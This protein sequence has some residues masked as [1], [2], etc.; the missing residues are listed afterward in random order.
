MPERPTPMPG[1]GAGIYVHVPFCLRKCCYCDF[2]S[3]P[4]CTEEMQ[5]YFEALA[6]EIETVA[7]E[8]L[9]VPVTSIFVGG[10][11]PS[12][13]PCA[14]LCSILRQILSMFKHSPDVEVSVEVNPGTVNA[15]SLAA[16]RAAGANRLSIGVQ[17]LDS[18]LLELLGRLHTAQDAVTS[19]LAARSAGFTNISIDLMFGLPEQ[20]MPHFRQTLEQVLELTPDHVSCYS[21]I[22]EPSTPLATLLREN[23]L[24]LPDEETELA[25]YEWAIERLRSA[26]YEQYEISNW[27]RPGHRCQHNEIYWRNEWYRGLGP[28]AHSHWGGQRWANTSDVEAYSRGLEQGLLPIAERRQLSP[29]D[30]MDETMIMGLRLLEGVSD[31]RFRSRFGRGLRSVYGD[32]IARL[33]RLGLVEYDTSVRLT[34]RGL[35]FGNQVFAAFLRSS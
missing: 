1:A 31:G 6:R 28:A 34:R 16:I 9:Q 15:T 8:M 12:V 22:V 13:L 30:E 2:V 14:M 3:Y 33:V 26:G 18:R 10:G 29:D 21:L 17:S 23:K 11:T 4:A 5:T 19:V 7:R 27:S 32:E 25:M 35:L 24:S 20:A